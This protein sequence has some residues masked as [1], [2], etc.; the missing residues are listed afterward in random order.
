MMSCCPSFFRRS[1]CVICCWAWLI[2][3]NSTIFLIPSVAASNCPAESRKL[4]TI[5]IMLTPSNKSFSPAAYFS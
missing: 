1:P 3:R 2:S 4:S 5:C